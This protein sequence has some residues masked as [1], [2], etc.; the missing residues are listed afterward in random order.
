[1]RRYFSAAV[2]GQQIVRV[3][4]HDPLDKIFKSPREALEKAL[5]GARFGETQRIG[6]YFFAHIASGP[7]LHLHFGMT[8]DLVLYRGN[9]LPKYTRFSFH[10]QSGQN[11]AF[12]D[13]RKFGVIQLTDDP[14]AFVKEL[15]LGPDLLKINPEDFSRR[16]RRGKVAIKTALLDQKRVAGI[17]NWIAD[18]MLFDCAIHPLTPAEKI[19]KEQAQQLWESGRAIVEQA[20]AEDTHYGAFPAGF[21]VHYRKGGALHPE[22]PDS[23]VEKLTVG[24]RGTYIVPARQKAGN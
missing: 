10:F 18:E 21:F 6:K 5:T 8:G 20:I 7:W 19:S 16:L 24:G 13:L 4:F 15:S 17:G 3:S 1:M 23:P 9:E 2:E 12:C 22:Y 11:L 14:L